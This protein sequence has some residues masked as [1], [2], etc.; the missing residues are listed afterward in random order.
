MKFWILVIPAIIIA[1][2]LSLGS[3]IS[4]LELEDQFGVKHVLGSERL[5]LLAWDKETTRLA[6]RYIDAHKSFLQTHNAA[7]VVDVSQVPSGIFSLFVKPRMQSYEHPILLS[8]D[9]KYNQQLPYQ[10]GC[11]TLLEL[12][13]QTV[14][15]VRF[16]CN[17]AQLAATF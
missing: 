12:Q 5:W 7:L 3:K 1:Q 11:V 14:S 6:N 8:F 10:E 4:A 2:T 13:N 17:E 9:A 16:A 15:S